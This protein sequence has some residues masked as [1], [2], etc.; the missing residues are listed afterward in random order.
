MGPL[1]VPTLQNSLGC[2]LQLCLDEKQGTRIYKYIRL[3]FYSWRSYL[4]GAEEQSQRVC[5]HEGVTGSRKSQW[6]TDFNKNLGTYIDYNSH[7]TGSNSFFSLVMITP[8]SHFFVFHWLQF[9]SMCCLFP[10]GYLPKVTYCVF[11]G[12]HF[13]HINSSFSNNSVQHKYTV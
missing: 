9:T 1:Y 7:V 8:T 13:I 10:I 6:T 2:I 11:P 12:S 5:T 4:R 3:Y